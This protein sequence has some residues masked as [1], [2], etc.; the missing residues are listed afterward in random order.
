M[1]Q[2]HQW[3]GNVVENLLSDQALE[4]NSICYRWS[5]ELPRVKVRSY[6]LQ[7]AWML[8]L[9][10]LSSSMLH[11]YGNENSYKLQSSWSCGYLC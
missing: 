8:L 5:Y 11:L 4:G 9:Y 1:K 7:A 3:P 6:S 2:N 10:D